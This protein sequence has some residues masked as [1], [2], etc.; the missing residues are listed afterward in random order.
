MIRKIYRIVIPKTIRQII[1]DRETYKEYQKLRQIPGHVYYQFD[2]TRSIFIHIP[3]GGGISTIKALYG[4][5]AKGFGHPSYKR[6]LR[7]YGKKSFSEYFKFT[8]VRNPWDRLLSAYNFLKKEGLNHMDQQFCDDVLNSYDTF[9]QF[10]MEWVNRGNVE[11]WVHFIPQYH[12]LYDDNMNLVV[13]F[14]GYFENFNDDFENVRA[15]LGTDKPLKHFNQTKSDKKNSYKEVY[16]LE[17]A[18]KVADVYKEDIE[19]FGYTF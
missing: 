16:T 3:K 6:F 14:V 4:E 12:Y 5:T 2:E 8:F 13:D 10:V 19:L 1:N 11:N 9:E 7:L 17:M 18:E 15:K